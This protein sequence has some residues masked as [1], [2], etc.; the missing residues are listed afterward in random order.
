[1]TYAQKISAGDAPVLITG[2]TGTGKDLMARYIH[3]HSHRSAGPLQIVNCAAV[4]PGLFES[5]FFGHVKGAYT[6]AAGGNNGHFLQANNGTLVLDEFTEIELRSQVKLL[7][8]IENQEIFP[9]GSQKVVRLNCRIIALTNRNVAALISAGKFRADLYHRLNQY[10][11]ELQPLSRRPGDIKALTLH[12]LG[13]SWYSLLPEWQKM[14]DSETFEALNAKRYPGNV[15]DLKNLI[16]KIL[17]F[18]S[19]A[20]PRITI[21][22]IQRIAGGRGP[23]GNKN[24]GFESESENLHEYLVR[25]ERNRIL[26]ELRRNNYNI[27]RTAEQLGLS[28]QNLQHRLKRLHVEAALR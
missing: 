16:L 10:H 24:Q 14:I 6:G 18:K 8:A 1:M 3:M 22:D 15:R 17:S 4:N 11:I 9:V 28:R 5:A 7:R 21:G 13:Q 23:V 27:T 19:P 12:F 2:E 26:E 25:V 20:N